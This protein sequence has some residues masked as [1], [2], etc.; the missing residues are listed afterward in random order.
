MSGGSGSS[1]PPGKLADPPVKVGKSHWGEVLNV[2]GDSYFSANNAQL[3]GRV[4]LFCSRVIR[5]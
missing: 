1:T 4:A 2:I 3:L 5:E